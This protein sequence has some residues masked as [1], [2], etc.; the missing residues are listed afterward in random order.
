MSVK[1][2]MNSRESKTHSKE[3]ELEGMHVAI[4]S[5]DAC[6]IVV[7]KVSHRLKQMN[8]GGKSKQMC[9]SFNLTCNHRHEILHTKDCHPA[10]WY[11]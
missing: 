1:F 7:E 11:S 2:P 8:L 4:G 9:C 5:M 6:H 10:R 3:F